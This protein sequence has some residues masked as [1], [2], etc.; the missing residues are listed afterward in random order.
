MAIPAVNSEPAGV[1]FV[2]KRNRLLSWN[3]LA[4]LM[5]RLNDHRTG[6][7]RERRKSGE[8]Q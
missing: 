5:R 6:P 7:N 8:C 2:A 3:I 4:S 1:M